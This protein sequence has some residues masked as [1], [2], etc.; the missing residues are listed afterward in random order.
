M[1]K[2]S[3]KT[4]AANNKLA[5]CYFHLSVLLLPPI[6][7]AEIFFLRFNRQAWNLFVLLLVT[8]QGTD[9]FP[10]WPVIQRQKTAYDTSLPNLSVI[11]F[12]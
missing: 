2:F 8:L 10:T 4:V 5:W 7:A 6:Q 9:S 12:V 11:F 1:E 3:L